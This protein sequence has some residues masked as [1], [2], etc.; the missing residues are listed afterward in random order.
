MSYKINTFV[1]T[2][3]ALVSNEKKLSICLGTDGFSFSERSL[4]GELLSLCDA[5]M[6]MSRA[7]SA[8]VDDVRGV[9]SQ[10][11]IQPLGYAECE[12][13]VPSGLFVWIP[14][15]LYDAAQERN[16]LEALGKV[17]AESGVFS[18]YNEVINSRMVFAAATRAVSAFK[19]AIPHL[20]VRSQ[21]DKMVNYTAM[22]MSAQ[23]S[24]LLMHLRRGA[25]DYALYG[26]RKFLMC[27]SY[28][29]ANVD[30]ML[31]YALNIT[32]DFHIEEPGLRVALC[33]EVDRE[34][35]G[36]IRPFF[37]E[38][39]LFT[40]EPLTLSEPEMQHLPL[41]RYALILS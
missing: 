25:A 12:L 23:R 8:L 35:F 40:G 27:N 22:E 21:Q 17:T 28:G 34:S 32:K 31:Y 29:C 16:Y 15:H 24:L 33:G 3:K 36:R 14:E 30:E 39:V 18:S 26:N 11:G 5:T 4:R 9:L 10:T 2:R 1:A 13:I 41:Y 38:A 19:I 7:M 37:P 20:V 6:D